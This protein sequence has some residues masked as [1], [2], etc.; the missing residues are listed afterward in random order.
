MVYKLKKALIVFVV[1]ILGNST[2]IPL[3]HGNTGLDYSIS[4]EK[5]VVDDRGNILMHVN[6]LGHVKNPGYHLVHE[7][8]D[9]IAVISVAGGYLPGANLKEITLIRESADE[10]NKTIY[11]LDLNKFYKTGDRENL[12][13]I[14]PNDTIVIEEKVFSRIFSRNNTL[15]SILQILNIY[16][17]ITRD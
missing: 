2:I 7:G 16:L 10:K 8:I 17:Q 6:M 9:I 13:K 14:L 1:L 11:V 15:N 12:V 5:Y 3:L 4:N